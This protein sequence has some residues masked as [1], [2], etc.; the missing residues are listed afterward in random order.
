M[1]LT[2]FQMEYLKNS[3][4]EPED[5]D[6]GYFFTDD[7]QASIAFDLDQLEN[8]LEA[9]EKRIEEIEKQREKDGHDENIDLDELARLAV[10][11]ELL[12][13]KC[14]EL[15]ALDNTLVPRLGDYEAYEISWKA[16]DQSEANQE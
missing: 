15:V 12:E 16:L 6:E 14:D 7:M 3:I 8:T 1:R 4:D 11:S 2:A 9:V 10:R 13:Q 5:E